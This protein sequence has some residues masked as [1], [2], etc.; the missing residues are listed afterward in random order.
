MTVTPAVTITA[1]RTVFIPVPVARFVS[2]LVPFLVTRFV[3]RLATGLFP[4]RAVVSPYGGLEYHDCPCCI[5]EPADAG[6][7]TEYG[8]GVK[9]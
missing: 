3:A 1:V 6:D 9:G 5:A 4:V 7:V 2:L 8:S